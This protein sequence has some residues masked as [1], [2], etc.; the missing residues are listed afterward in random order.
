MLLRVV[1]V[2]VDEDGESGDGGME[3]RVE[4]TG[5]ARSLGEP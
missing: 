2:W 4:A 1:W 5:L 3:E